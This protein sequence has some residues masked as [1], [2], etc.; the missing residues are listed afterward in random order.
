[1]RE[2]PTHTAGKIFLAVMFISLFLLT[3]V[4]PFLYTDQLYLGWM[5]GPFFYGIIVT[6]IWG[7]A[8]YVYSFYYW[9]YR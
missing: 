7:V 3:F 1:V 8:L 2:I 6:V 9:P 4:A 5:S